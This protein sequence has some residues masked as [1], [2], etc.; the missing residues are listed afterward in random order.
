MF[1]TLIVRSIGAA[2]TLIGIVGIS[3][4]LTLWAPFAIIS[5]EVSKRDALRRAKQPSRRLE[6]L[7]TEEIEG[8]GGDQAGV[9]LGI[10]N[11]SVATPQILATVGSSIIFKFFQK[12]RGTPGDH[13]IAIVLACGGISTLVAAF[14]TSRIK[15]E[16]ELPEEFAYQAVEEGRGRAETERRRRSISRERSL[17]RSESY[18]GLEY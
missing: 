14:L 2:T 12:P 1:S 17:V 6:D 16:V 5:A 10:H 15:D 18:G 4:A 11:M 13:S 9:I 8:A 7:D 3:W